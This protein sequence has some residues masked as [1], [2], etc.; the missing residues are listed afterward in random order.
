MFVHFLAAAGERKQRVVGNMMGNISE[1]VRISKHP[2]C[3]HV[4][5]FTLLLLQAMV[6]PKATA[7]A[8]Y[9]SDS[10][11]DQFKLNSW[12]VKLMGC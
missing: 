4:Y 11:V 9:Q 8:I 12:I 2:F 7:K 5:T 6:L 1:E 10:P 3:K